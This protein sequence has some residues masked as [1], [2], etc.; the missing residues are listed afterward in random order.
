MMHGWQHLTPADR[1]TILLG[2]ERGEPLGGPFHVELDPIDICNADCFFCNSVE[3]RNGDIF[4]WSELEP[5]L[6]EL[7]AGGL[8]SIRLAGGGEP[9]LYPDLESLCA[10]LNSA[11]VVLDNLTTNGIRLDAKRIAQLLPLGPTHFHISLN[12]ASP[13]KYEQFMQIPGDRFTTIL[14]NVK[15]LDEKMIHAAGRRGSQIHL[16]FFIHASTI[17]DMPEMARIATELPVD[18]VTLRAISELPENEQLS[19]IDIERLKVELPRFAD[20]VRGRTWL[21]LDLGQYGLT[22]ISNELLS[23]QQDSGTGATHIR[24]AAGRQFCYIGWYS[25]AVLGT[26]AV[27]PCCYLMPDPTIPA[28]GNLKSQSVAQVWHGDHYRQFRKEMRTAMIYREIAAHRQTQV[29]CTQPVCWSHDGCP[30]AH[31]LATDD[32]YIEADTRLELIRWSPADRLIRFGERMAGL[33][34]R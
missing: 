27:H 16:Q 25:M 24:S 33:F 28:F 1:E 30:I 22:S 31:N 34:A 23:K 26:G 20:A 13:H 9:T 4:R 17:E 12:Y 5:I 19:S 32:F 18:T 6:D 15:L 14:N 11:G 3:Y 2:I 29:K 21:M 8:R 7:I 10:K